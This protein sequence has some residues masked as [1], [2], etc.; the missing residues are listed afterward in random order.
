MPFRCDA[1]TLERLEWPRLARCLSDLAA[2]ERASEALRAEDGRAL[3][4]ETRAG[5]LDLLAETGEM[6]GLLDA[7]QVPPFG[8][9]ADLR[10]DVDEAAL[11]SVLSARQLARV[12]GT[13]EAAGRLHAFFAERVEQAPRLSDLAGTLPDF[14]ALV[15]GLRD[16]ITPEGEVRDDASPAL[17]SAR[18]QARSLESEIEGRMAKLLRDASLH[19]HLQDH[20][21]TT[22]EGR[23]VLPVRSDARG[24]VKGIVHD[25]SSSGTTVFIEPEAV[26]ELGNRLRLAQLDVTREI[27]RLLREA[28]ASVATE[29]IAIDAA[30]VTLEALDCALARGRLSQRVGGSAL[31][32]DGR[33]GLRQLRHPLLILEAGLE[34]DDVV[35]NDVVLPEEVRGLVISGPNAGGKT[36]FAKALGL[37]ALSLRAGLHVACEDGSA[38]PLVDAV[39]ADI[40]DEQDLRSGLSTFSARM[41]N[42]AQ[43]LEQV[44]EAALVILDE[45]GEGTEPGEGAALAQ[46]MLESLVERGASVVATTHFNRLKELAGADARFANASAEFDAETLMPTYRVRVGAP[47]SSG[48]TWVAERMGVDAAVVRRARA[49]LDSEDRKLESL[50]RSLSELRQELEAE[51]AEALRVLEQS[52]SARKAYE[53]RLASLRTAREEALGAMKA[54]LEG[55]FREARDEI[56]SVMRD[57][58][59]GRTGPAANRAQQKLDLV[60]EKTERVEQEHAEPEPRVDIDWSAVEPGAR[61]RVDG[62][63]GEPVYV[64]G[65]D[66][67]GRVVIRGGAARATID[68]GRVRRVL[69]ALPKPRQGSARPEGALRIQVPAERA[70]SDT[71]SECDLRGLRVDEALDRADA[72]LQKLLGSGVRQVSFIHG[73]GTGALRSAIRSWLRELP[74]VESFEPAPRNQGGDGVTVAVLT[75]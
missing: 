14:A 11:G 53:E 51:R 75:H 60:Q 44:D 62:I 40:G 27:E 45:V 41:A 43:V 55:A 21:V 70:P 7:E 8:G 9:I 46:A 17:R 57:L 56:G 22:R 33:I 52:E 48:A 25:L 38:L 42:L 13:L 67:R 65:P 71:R 61:L 73:H 59:R 16:V 10:P 31:Q 18:R 12:L 1:A 64:E 29:R 37:A 39:H 47:G 58:Q 49:L 5:A 3:L 69:A 54:E 20:F 30:G 74:F 34:L 15:R 19:P 66:R 35:P 24:R 63:P 32:S 2:T 28:T 68:S 26:V 72:H 6:R 36:V 4:A 23:P 50:T